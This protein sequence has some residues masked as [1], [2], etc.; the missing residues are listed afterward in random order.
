VYPIEECASP[1]DE[2]IETQRGESSAA[3][4]LFG[5][6]LSA[7]GAGAMEC[8]TPVALSGGLW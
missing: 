4:V 6:N 7:R 5:V 8:A 1:F 3:F 2:L